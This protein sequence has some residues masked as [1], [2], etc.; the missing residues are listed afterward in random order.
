MED[1]MHWKMSSRVFLVAT[2]LVLL[3]ALSVLL[4]SCGG[5]GGG[6]GGVVGDGGT[7][8]AGNTGPAEINSGNIVNFAE[9]VTGGVELP[10]MFSV[11]VAATTTS[12]V[13]TAIVTMSSAAILPPSEHYEGSCGGTLDLTY[14]IN[15]SPSQIEVTGKGVTVNY[16]EDGTIPTN[17]ST[18]GGFLDGT[19]TITMGE[20]QDRIWENVS[21][22]SFSASDS[23]PALLMELDGSINMEWPFGGDPV[24]LE[25]IVVRFT[26]SGVVSEYWLKDFKLKR[27]NSGMNWVLTGQVYYG[28]EGYVWLETT[29]PL[30]PLSPPYIETGLILGTVVMHGETTDCRLLFNDDPAYKV[31][32]WNGS[33][34]ADMMCF[35]DNWSSATCAPMPP[36]LSNITATTVT[37]M[38]YR[39]FENSANDRFHAFIDLRNN[40]QFIQASDVQSVELFDKDSVQIIPAAPPQFFTAV[41]TIAQWNTT[42]SQFESIAA[43]G[44]SGYWFNLSNYASITLGAVRFVVQPSQGV[45]FNYDVNFPAQTAL[46]PV[47]STSMSS[48]WNLDGSLTLSWSEPL[49]IFDQYRITLEDITGEGIFGGRVPLGVTQVTLSA[50]L[51]EEIRLT[52]QLTLPT[53]I[54]WRMQTR[55]YEGNTNY[56]RSFSDPVSIN[57]P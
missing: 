41:Y 13:S 30:E 12:L 31:E 35:D 39:T 54:N 22:S 14:S 44:D 3:G 24:Y 50:S 49:D 55:N 47:A 8:F 57:W 56:A 15:E 46:T 52:S 32:L 45:S 19:F 37:F 9:G 23:A 40:G 36:T 1:V 2:Y 29:A 21:F 25:N 26:D 53:T 7:G 34:W 33:E 5:G 20:S 51:L 10:F 38:Q 16:C 6:D 28:E 27:D 17:I 43:T 11:D 4:V 48:Q 18:E 42:T